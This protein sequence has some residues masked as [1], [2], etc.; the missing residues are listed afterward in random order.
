MS[1][2]VNV[3]LPKVSA[4]VA[5]NAM[6]KIDELRERCGL[7]EADIGLLYE[8]SV[9]IFL[10]ERTVM[11]DRIPEKCEHASAPENLVQL[12]PAPERS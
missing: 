10:R 9:T 5:T 7:S 2:T 4:E 8:A 11:G 12:M 3:N 1:D 6:D